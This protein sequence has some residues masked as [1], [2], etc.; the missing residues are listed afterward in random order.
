MRS[1]SLPSALVSLV[2]LQP[3]SLVAASAPALPRSACLHQKSE[4]LAESVKCGDQAAVRACF[5]AAP[6]T[7]S[8]NY[9]RECLLDAGCGAAQADEEGRWLSAWCSR[10]Y[11]SDEQ[12]LE[13]AADDEAAELKRRRPEP[14]PAPTPA[15]DAEN[16]PLFIREPAT[17]PAVFRR[18]SSSLQCSTET[19]IEI[20]SCEPDN[21]YKCS[22]VMTTTSVCA[23]GNICLRDKNGNNICMARQDGLTT[24][25]AVVAIFLAVVLAMTI[26]TI[27]FLCCKDRREAKK[28]R[29]RA[30]AAAIAKANATPAPRSEAREAARAARQA[31]NA[32]QPNPFN[33]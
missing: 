27:G 13:P 20:D 12:P 15:A 31:S 11:G 5:A 7:L 10:T 8:E 21:K 18:T 16:S 24:S 4:S 26:G 23:D 30:E 2:L 33:G 29:A 19:S 25:G 3:A 32:S 22:K 14:V 6:Q 17:T 9:I 1:F 28:A